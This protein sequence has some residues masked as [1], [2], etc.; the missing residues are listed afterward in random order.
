MDRLGAD[1]DILGL[2]AVRHGESYRVPLAVAYDNELAGSVYD[3]YETDF[4]RFGYDRESW[5]LGE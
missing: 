4:E 5:R 3:F 1:R 2:G